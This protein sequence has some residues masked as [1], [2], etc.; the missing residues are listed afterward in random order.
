[1]HGNCSDVPVIP[2]HGR[3]KGGVI[4]QGPGIPVEC[5]ARTS[6]VAEPCLVENWEL[7]E[8]PRPLEQTFRC[9][10]IPFLSGRREQNCSFGSAALDGC[11]AGAKMSRY[12]PSQR[13]LACIFLQVPSKFVVFP[14]PLSTP[15][16]ASS[17]RSSGI[18]PMG[19]L[20]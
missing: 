18:G 14:W 10:H 9:V 16:Q 6:A 1:M 12:L 4:I 17:I 11:Q 20:E 8:G 19:Q 5:S 15:P 3:T 7:G 2:L 13:L